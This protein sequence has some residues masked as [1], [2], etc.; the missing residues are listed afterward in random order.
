MM[1][2]TRTP[3]RLIAA[4]VVPLALATS[5][6]MALY[7]VANGRAPSMRA[8]LLSPVPAAVLGQGRW[9][10]WRRTRIADAP[11]TRAKSAGQPHL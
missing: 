7:A 10:R 3:I 5:T 11:E 6:L 8:A 1:P 9:D 4:I 2:L